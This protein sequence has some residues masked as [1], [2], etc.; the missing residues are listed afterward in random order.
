MKELMAMTIVLLI[1]GLM[2]FTVV[3]NSKDLTKN[4]KQYIIENQNIN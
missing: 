2:A 3:A 1:T 4:I